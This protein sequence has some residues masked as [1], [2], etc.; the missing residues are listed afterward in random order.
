MFKRVL[1]LIVL[2]TAV[3]VISPAVTKGQAQC[4]REQEQ[5]GETP[6]FAAL[7]CKIQ[8]YTNAGFDWIDAAGQSFFDSLIDS[9]F[10]SPYDEAF[11]WKY[12]SG[13]DDVLFSDEGGDYP[14]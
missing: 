14:D 4:I 11:Y 6:S 3:A 8:A 2:A 13:E 1:Q 7:A 5:R 10:G 9:F 12:F